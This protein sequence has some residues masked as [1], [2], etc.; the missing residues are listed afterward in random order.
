M[1][2]SGSSG[3]G[4]SISTVWSASFRSL[5]VATTPSSSEHVSYAT[6]LSPPNS[7]A[8]NVN[9]NSTVPLPVSLALNVVLAVVITLSSLFLINSP[10]SVYSLPGIKLL[11]FTSSFTFASAF[12]STTLSPSSASVAVVPISGSS[13]FSSYT[14]VNVSVVASAFNVFSDSDSSGIPV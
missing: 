4:F 5:C 10:S 13:G 2:I 8:S 7:L 3:S 1:P 11:Y 14:F 9:S 12:A 6:A